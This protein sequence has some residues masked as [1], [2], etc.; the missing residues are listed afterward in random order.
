MQLANGGLNG[1]FH[2]DPD[3]KIDVLFFTPLPPS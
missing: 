3:G 1:V 2:T